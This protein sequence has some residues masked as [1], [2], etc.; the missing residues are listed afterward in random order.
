MP[1]G[2][3]I[4]GSISSRIRLRSRPEPHSMSDLAGLEGKSDRPEVQRF[5]TEAIRAGQIRVQPCPGAPSRV[6]I[7]RLVASRPR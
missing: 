7:V 4:D 1:I 3:S 2:L 5:L 6:Q